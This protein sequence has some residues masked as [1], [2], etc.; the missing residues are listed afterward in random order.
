[1]AGFSLIVRQRTF[2]QKSS[3]VFLK[4]LSPRYLHDHAPV[5]ARNRFGFP[6]SPIFSTKSLPT[7][8]GGYSGSSGATSAS[9]PIYTN[10]TPLGSELRPIPPNAISASGRMGPATPANGIGVL[11]NLPPGYAALSPNSSMQQQHNMSMIPEQNNFGDLLGW[12]QSM[13][14]AGP[15]PGQSPGHNPNI[16]Y[17]PQMVP[18]Y[19][20]QQ[21]GGGKRG[22][23][24]KGHH[25]GQK[26]G[27]WG[28]GEYIAPQSPY[29][30]YFGD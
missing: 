14:P 19:V 27:G 4:I 2:T 9:S 5:T 7:P 16:V 1:M 3:R 24:G 20:P 25:S 15:P 22:S 23:K 11:P 10:V 28:G 29:A 21:S 17:V 30:Q 26:G 13:E 6:L 8:Q 18:V 12:S